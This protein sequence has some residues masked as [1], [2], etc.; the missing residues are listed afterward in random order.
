MTTGTRNTLLGIAA[1][2]SFAL[3]LLFFGMYRAGGMTTEEER[4]IGYYRF[5]E[6]RQL[7]EF[8]LTDHE[9]RPANLRSLRG[10]W[11]VLFFGFT[12]CSHICPTTLK[13]V[14]RCAE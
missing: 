9:G 6:P 14:G 10:Q 8:S 7:T 1:T 2:I 11:T 3:G 12:S 4:A 13:G 5:D